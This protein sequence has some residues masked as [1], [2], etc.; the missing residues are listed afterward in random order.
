[1]CKGIKIEHPVPEVPEMTLALTSALT[2]ALKLRIANRR[3]TSGWMAW[4]VGS[5]GGRKWI[6]GGRARGRRR[7]ATADTTRR[8]RTRKD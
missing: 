1:M 7:Q 8:R 5:E 3:K 6:E 2:L 4:Q